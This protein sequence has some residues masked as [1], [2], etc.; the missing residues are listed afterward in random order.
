MACS[1]LNAAAKSRA[2]MRL[3]R[4]LVPLDY[5]RGDRFVHDP[6]LPLPPWSVLDPLRRLAAAP[7][8]GDDE[9]FAEVDAI[10][11]RNRIAGMLAQA[12]RALAFPTH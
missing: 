2:L 10:R 7:R 8:G 5:T 11:A 6:A 12:R 9:R 3:S 1:S 4:M